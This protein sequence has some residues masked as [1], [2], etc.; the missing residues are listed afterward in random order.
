MSKSKRP[1]QTSGGS[2]QLQ[3]LNEKISRLVAQKPWSDIYR[4]FSVAGQLRGNAALDSN[5][6][7]STR[8]RLSRHLI[9]SYVYGSDTGKRDRRSVR[10]GDWARGGQENT[11]C[12]RCKLLGSEQ[13]PAR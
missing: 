13:A 12:I 9:A 11:L 2:S 6:A 10:N 4:S 5:P 8:Y 1:V 3:R 7:R